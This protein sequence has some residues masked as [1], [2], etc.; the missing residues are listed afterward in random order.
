M[1]ESAWLK[2]SRQNSDQMSKSQMTYFLSMSALTA[3][4]VF[5]TAGDFALLLTVAA[6]GTALFGILSFDA[7]QQGAITMSK[8]MPESIAATP[9]GE[10]IREV[11]QYSSIVRRMRS[12]QQELQLFRL[13]Q[14]TELGG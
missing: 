14:L 5:S 3:T 7:A 13:S 12:S 2:M 11:N 9:I 1:N 6:V 10:A 4:I 8:S